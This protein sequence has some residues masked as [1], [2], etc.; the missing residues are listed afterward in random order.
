MGCC[1][2]VSKSNYLLIS[3]SQWWWRSVPYLCVRFFFL[4]RRELLGDILHVFVGGLRLIL[5]ALVV[6]PP[7]ITGI[8]IK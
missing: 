3:C 7:L 5:R 2:L 1:T 8:K 4:R 6:T